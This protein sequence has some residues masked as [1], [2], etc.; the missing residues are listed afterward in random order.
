QESKA[1]YYKY[2]VKDGRR[3]IRP[4][5][6]LAGPLLVRRN[7]LHHRCDRLHAILELLGVVLGSAHECVKSR[8]G[9][10]HGVQSFNHACVFRFLTSDGFVAALAFGRG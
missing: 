7:Q 8:P 1:V 5:G 10:R 3:V 6:P 2:L 9:F 4:S